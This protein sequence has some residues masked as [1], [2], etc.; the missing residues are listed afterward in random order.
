MTIAFSRASWHGRGGAQAPDEVPCRPPARAPKDFPGASRHPLQQSWR[1]DIPANSIPDCD[2]GEG[3]PHWSLLHASGE[4]G[5]TRRMRAPWRQAHFRHGLL[6]RYPPMTVLIATF[7]R[8]TNPLESRK[9]QYNV[10]PEPLANL[11]IRA[12]FPAVLGDFP[13]IGSPI[14]LW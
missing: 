3:A 8:Q 14:L 2:N 11:Q 6:A 1:G 4:G 7:F 13:G 9:T 5:A 12:E 10:A